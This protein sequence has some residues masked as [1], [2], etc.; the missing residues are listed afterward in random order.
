MNE[1]FRVSGG[2]K[3]LASVV[4]YQQNYDF[5]MYNFIS[6]VCMAVRK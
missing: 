1:S 5:A 3:A 2:L 4:F 6:N